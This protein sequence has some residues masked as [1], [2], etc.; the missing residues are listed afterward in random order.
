MVICSLAIPARRKP[1]A[2][3]AQAPVSKKAA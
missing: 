2:D 3:E 1:A